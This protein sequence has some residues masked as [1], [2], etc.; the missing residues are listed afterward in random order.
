MENLI[1]EVLECIS[2]TMKEQKFLAD[3]SNSV[4]T[5]FRD[6]NKSGKYQIS[7]I[8]YIAKVYNTRVF[9]YA[10]EGVGDVEIS[11]SQVYNMNV[12]SGYS[13]S[14]GTFGGEEVLDCNVFINKEFLT[15]DIKNFN[16]S[17]SGKFLLNIRYLLLNIIHTAYP[18][19]KDN[20]ANI[21]ASVCAVVVANKLGLAITPTMIAH[22]FELNPQMGEM[23][24]DKY[25]YEKDCFIGIPWLF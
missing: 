20:F 14:I 18:A 17:K 11:N 1:R 16:E 7:L 4:I 23:I 19:M 12:N 2:N 8:P 10:L 21:S 22:Y 15:N 3:H 13:V 25:D 5:Q 24:I 6:A 9:F